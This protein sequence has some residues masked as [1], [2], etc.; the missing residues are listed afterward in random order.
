MRE[1][2]NT[3]VCAVILFVVLAGTRGNARAAPIFE[4]GPGM[5]EP[6]K[7]A[8]TLSVTKIIDGNPAGSEQ[9]L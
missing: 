3:A 6:N 7:P 2:L 1:C 5:A 9:L 4:R 8:E